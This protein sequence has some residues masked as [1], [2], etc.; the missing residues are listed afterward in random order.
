[1]KRRAFIGRSLALGSGL[2]VLL[3]HSVGAQEAKATAPQKITPVMEMVKKAML[4]MQRAPWEQGVAVQAL[5][6]MGENDLVVLMA[7]EAVV[8]QLEDGRLGMLYTQN[9]VTDPASNGEAVLLAGRLTGATLFVKAAARMRTYLLERAPKT[10]DGILHHN[11]DKP[12]VWSDAGYMAPPFLAVAGRPDEAVKQIEGFRKLLWN[13]EKKLYSHIWDDGKK[14]FERQDCWGVGNGWT[15]AGMAR[16]IKALPA[17]MAEDKKRLAGYV[18]D[19]LDGCL[20][21]QRRDG[22]FHDVVDNPQ[23]FV[24]TNL[25]QMLAYTVY[26]GIQGGWLDPSYRKAADR[27][28]RAAKGKIDRFGLVEGVCGSPHFDR[29]GTAT[30]GQAFFLLMEAAANELGPA[31]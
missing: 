29:P 27:M 23:T 28:R 6:E 30:E 5:L 21:H 13:P 25:A 12:Q 20:V 11:N 14:A 1:M 10:A 19:I 2:P 4:C 7:K 16:V 18:K 17:A 9:A 26:R 15:A 24:E 31:S 3:G 22:L 8:R